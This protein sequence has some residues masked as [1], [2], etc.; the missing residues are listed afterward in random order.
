MK[1]TPFTFFGSS[2]FSVI[3]LDELAAAGLVPTSVVTTPDK[4]KGRHLVMTPTPVKE[5]AAKRGIPVL[6]PEILDEDF[7]VALKSSRD[8]FMLVASYGKIIPQAVLDGPL[9]SRSHHVDKVDNKEAAKV[10]KSQLARDFIG[11]FE[12]GV[13]RRFLDIAAFGGAGRVDI[14]GGERF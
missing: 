8:S 12:I 7:I 2:R 5:W 4:P 10:S 3:V 9:V 1:N 14:N 13:E 6:D 11:R